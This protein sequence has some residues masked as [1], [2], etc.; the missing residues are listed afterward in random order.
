MFPTVY[1]LTSSPEGQVVAD[2]LWAVSVSQKQQGNGS[3]LTDTVYRLQ[4]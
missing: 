4:L 1:L 2:T 3:L